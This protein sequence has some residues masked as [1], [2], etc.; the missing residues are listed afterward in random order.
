MEPKARVDR[1]EQAQATGN[2]TRRRV[3]EDAGNCHAYSRKYSRFVRL[4]LLGFK[5]PYF[6]NVA[7]K[8]DTQSFLAAPLP[9]SLSSG[10]KE[11]INGSY[12]IVDRRSWARTM[13]HCFATLNGEFAFCF[14]KKQTS[15]SAT[16]CAIMMSCRCEPNKRKKNK[17]E[18]PFG[19]SLL[20]GSP[21][22]ARTSD[23]MI[24]SHALYR[25]S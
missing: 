6:R 21:C 16:S 19:Y 13:R 9:T 5:T 7:V 4:R 14:T 11:S 2:D 25:L 18:Q 23:I 15:L 1:A 20:F 24:N 12:N 3:G 8:K 22:W 17:R 10:K